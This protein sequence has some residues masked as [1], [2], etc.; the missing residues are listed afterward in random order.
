V[1]LGECLRLTEPV[2]PH[3]W[4]G[5]WTHLCFLLLGGLS[6]V[7]TNH[8]RSLSSPS[9]CP[10]WG[11]VCAGV[12]LEGRQ[13]H[14]IGFT[15]CLCQ[16]CSFA[17]PGPLLLMLR[18]DT[19]G[20]GSGSPMHSWETQGMAWVLW[21]TSGNWKMRNWIRPFSFLLLDRDADASLLRGRGSEIKQSVMHLLTG[22]SSF[23]A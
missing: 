6:E 20:H 17:S 14:L 2:F 22:F 11:Q 1:L 21:Q 9:S 19:E 4:N 10:S 7:M 13:L 16:V 18:R 12:A 8:F 5:A 15:L 3:V 23:T